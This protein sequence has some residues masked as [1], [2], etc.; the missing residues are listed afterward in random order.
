MNDDVCVNPIPVEK[1]H[2]ISSDK[3][4]YYFNEYLAFKKQNHKNLRLQEKLYITTERNIT[5]RT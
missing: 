3:N 1:S 2:T 4:G 5:Y